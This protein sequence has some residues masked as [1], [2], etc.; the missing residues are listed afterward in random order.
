[1]VQLPENLADVSNQIATRCAASEGNQ[2]AHT[3]RGGL[4]I[5]P[6][7]YISSNRPWQDLRAV[8]HEPTETVISLSSTTNESLAVD[9]PNDF[10]LEAAQW[11]IG[12]TGEIELVAQKRVEVPANCL[13]HS[14]QAFESL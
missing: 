6:I 5:N 1:M 11:Q 9:S 10:V 14:D 8:T 7:N 2:F 3:G 4:P 12:A 13:G